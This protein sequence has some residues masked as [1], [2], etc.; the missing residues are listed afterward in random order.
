MLQTNKDY[1][2]N[3]EEIR[4]SLLKD[5]LFGLT[6]ETVH[7]VMIRLRNTQI[8][9]VIEAN[10]QWSGEEEILR[11]IRVI[12]RFHHTQRWCNEH[13][14]Y[15]MEILAWDDYFQYQ[16]DWKWW[17]CLSVKNSMIIF[18]VNNLFVAQVP[19]NLKIDSVEKDKRFV[20]MLQHFDRKLAN[21]W[22]AKPHICPSL[23]WN[24]FFSS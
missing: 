23:N 17:I 5:R 16:F 6:Q 13:T 1:W 22:K 18:A 14:K 9:I 20:H 12:M 11:L 2:I 15:Q 3:Q 21:H 24:V 7:T 19:N 4:E 8:I 10:G